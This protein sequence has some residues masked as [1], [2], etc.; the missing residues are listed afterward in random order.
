MALHG[1][2]EACLRHPNG[3]FVRCYCTAWFS[4]PVLDEAVSAYRLHM[5]EPTLP[6]RAEPVQTFREEALDA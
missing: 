3:G 4:S 1:I 5:T 6:Q 2:K